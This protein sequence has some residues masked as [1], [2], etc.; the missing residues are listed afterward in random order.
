MMNKQF[1]S[2]VKLI[3]SIVMIFMMVQGCDQK[4]DYDLYPAHFSEILRSLDD[5][6]SQRASLYET[7]EIFRCYQLEEKS[8]YFVT[9]TKGYEEDM[10]IGVKMNEEAIEAV[11]I[12]Y[13]NESEKYGEYVTESWFLDRF[14]MPF[15]G[16]FKL[17]KK[18]KKENNEV[19]AI[20]GATITSQFVMDA[21]NRCIVIM[22]EEE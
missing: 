17:V 22:E 10:L 2:K 21:V 16:K 18:S 13:E 14:V 12:L 7:K 19:V 4:V 20:T 9:V 8:Y 15:E 11:E 5:T 1:D 3:I 6:Y